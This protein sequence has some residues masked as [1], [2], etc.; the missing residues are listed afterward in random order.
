MLTLSEQRVEELE[1]KL[2]ALEQELENMRSRTSSV[3][4]VPEV[5]S[6]SKVICFRK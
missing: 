5:K 3:Q 6:P 4:F 2:A 1:D